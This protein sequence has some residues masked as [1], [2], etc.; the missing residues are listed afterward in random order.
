[1][2]KASARSSLRAGVAFV[3]RQADSKS[4]QDISS[5]TELYPRIVGKLL[6]RPED[7]EQGFAVQGGILL[8]GITNGPMES[9]L[10]PAEP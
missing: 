7:L 2:R 3:A 10:L 8:A 6:P 1:M 9:T 5:G 4:K